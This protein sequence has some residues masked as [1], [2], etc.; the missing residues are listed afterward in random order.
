MD[1]TTIIAYLENSWR[2]APW[3]LVLQLCVSAALGGIIGFEREYHH[4]A[5][6]FRTH[7]LVALG[8]TLFTILSHSVLAWGGTALIDP[9]RIAA[10]SITGIGFIGAGAILRKDDRIEGL[11]TAAGIWAT[12]AIGMAVGVGLYFIS[13]IAVVLIYVMR[14]ISKFVNR[15]IDKVKQQNGYTHK[16]DYKRD[17]Q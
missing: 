15:T 11:T 7:F 4:K 3:E 13:A 6:G 1:M 2:N 10:Q 5:A 8:S 9:T 14:F 17:Q 12:A 16:S